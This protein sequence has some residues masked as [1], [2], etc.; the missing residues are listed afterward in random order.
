M[1][2]IITLFI[3]LLL[4]NCEEIIEVEDISGDRISILAPTE[5]SV[6]TDPNVTFSWNSLEDAEFY[7]L[8]IATPSFENAEQIE[9]DSLI[10]SLNFSK[11]LYIGQ[12]E[13]RVRGENSEFETSYTTQNF[14]I[15]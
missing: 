1:K 11:E 9:L 3:L 14:T 6:L 10:S 2:K 8:Q 12:F 4:F 7:R 13:W 15:E 5:A